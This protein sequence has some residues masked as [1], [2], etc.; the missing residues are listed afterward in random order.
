MRTLITLLK[1][2]I[3]EYSADNCSHMAAAISYYVLFS[4][5]PLTVFVVSIFGFAVRDRDLQERVSDEIVSFINIE[6]GELSLEPD[7][8]RIMQRYGASA[9]Q[10]IQ[11]ALDELTPPEVEQLAAALDADETVLIADRELGP[12]ELAVRSDNIVIDTIQGVSKVSGALTLV[13]L[14]GMAWSA[15]A[16]FGAIRKSIN[17]AW[18]LERHRPLVQQKLIDLG[19][20]LGLGAVLLISVVSTGTLRTLRELSDKN[21]GPISEGTSVLWDIL[22]FFLPA[23]FS[24]LMFALIYRSV[25]ATKVRFGDIWPG[26]LLATILFEIVKNGFAVYV[27]NFN[28]YDV[29]FGALGGIMI[30][31][32]WVYITS[33][34]LLLGAEMA[35][36]F[37]RVRRGEYPRPAPA[38]RRPLRQAALRTAKGLFVHQEDEHAEAE[39]VPGPAEGEERQ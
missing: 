1:R 35:S 16:M 33:N 15:S 13:G 39:P 17:I 19:M 9:L 3:Q 38:P 6:Q 20:V 34:I 10:E 36:E 12:D 8:A 14:V 7:E 27:A 21:L 11:T 29:A 23:I 30:F 22:P 18:D 28:N 37:P 26:A 24:F 5:I 32:L 4:I 31:L 25:P 2:T